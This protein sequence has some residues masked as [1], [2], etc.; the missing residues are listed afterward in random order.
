[1]SEV[2]EASAQFTP[3][4]FIFEVEYEGD[5]WT[6][7]D[8]FEVLLETKEYEKLNKMLEVYP[9]LLLDLRYE[10]PDISTTFLIESINKTEMFDYLLSK[11]CDPWAAGAHNVNAFH[12]AGIVGNTASLKK[13]LLKDPNGI[14]CLDQF[15]RT[16]LHYAARANHID[17]VQLLL[18]FPMIDVNIRND[19][20]CLPE[21]QEKP[22][23]ITSNEES[24]KL[25]AEHRNHIR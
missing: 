13:L 6:F 24:C 12:F 2:E 21:D 25:I 16:P 7:N 14:N 11:G 20:G 1:M 10:S 18:T 4:K 19:D 9:T 22:I 17:T 15:N 5:V 3:G 8:V 23:G